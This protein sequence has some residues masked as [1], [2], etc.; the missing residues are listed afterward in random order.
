MGQLKKGGSLGCS[1]CFNVQS[2]R[3]HSSLPK[4]VRSNLTLLILGKIHNETDL[5]VIS[6][7]I[8]GEVSPEVFRRVYEQATSVPFGMLVVDMHPKKEH[9]SQFRRGLDTFIIV[10]EE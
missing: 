8:A 10:P 5:K 1:I 6:E 9:P 2:Y 7:E 4:S 3:S